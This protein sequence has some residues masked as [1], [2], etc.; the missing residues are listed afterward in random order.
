MCKIESLNNNVKNISV[1]QSVKGFSII[2][3]LIAV[4]LTGVLFI[5]Y[6]NIQ[7]AFFSGTKKTKQTS[8]ARNLSVRIDY[9]LNQPDFC[10]ILKNCDHA[11][12]GLSVCNLSKMD[13]EFKELT[14]EADKKGFEVLYNIKK[15]ITQRDEIGLISIR[16]LFK[17]KKTGKTVVATSATE[18]SVHLD[19]NQKIASCSIK[20]LENTCDGRGVKFL[21]E[22]SASSLNPTNS[23]NI[24]DLKLIHR[25]DGQSF[26]FKSGNI[27]NRP[28]LKGEYCLSQNVCNRGQWI[29]SA[30]C[31]DSCR[32]K[33]W[34]DGQ[35]QYVDAIE[36]E[37]DFVCGDL[38]NF[39]FNSLGLPACEKANLE[40]KLNFTT[41]GSGRFNAYK[42][43][44]QD[45][46]NSD[47]EI[48]A[49]FSAYFRCSYMGTWILNRVKCSNEKGVAIWDSSSSGAKDK[50]AL[51]SI[52]CETKG[53]SVLLE[54]YNYN[55]KPWETHKDERLKAENF[56]KNI[57]LGEVFSEKK[58][59]INE[60]RRL[61]AFF[62]D[63]P[64]GAT[65]LCSSNKKWSIEGAPVKNCDAHQNP[66][67]RA[68]IIFVIDNSGSMGG[69]Q[70]ALS[71]AIDNFISKFLDDSA[72]YINFSIT[73]TTTD[74]YM[75]PPFK[76][77]DIEKGTDR[78]RS[79][80]RPGTGGSGDERPLRALNAVL[81]ATGSDHR[82]SYQQKNNH[83]A[84]FIITDENNSET[85]LVQPIFDKIM[86]WKDNEESQVTVHAAVNGGYLFCD[87]SG[88]PQCL[89][90][91]FKGTL[92]DVGKSN[93]GDEMGRFAEEIIGKILVI[94]R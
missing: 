62:P 64:T 61:L 68:D 89:T 11:K 39:N 40:S 4:S 13:G 1:N 27:L 73:V 20:N 93:Y 7:T 9:L 21:T 31:Y 82:E 78:L 25:Q 74:S 28:K 58:F 87:N 94:G 49:K 42:V 80:M 70:Q 2:E 38:K 36:S 52:Q 34:R 37:V 43:H 47:K 5:G 66:R 14:D 15:A 86:R 32:N 41:G 53:H 54:S 48:T 85:Y 51:N 92:F 76:K 18:V 10:P 17:D 29:S 56:K 33:F 69:E 26:I 65:I 81:N 8:E 6:V 44:T 60:P 22:F 3:T 67:P 71:D 59:K 45:I 55:E 88:G 84:I 23:Q 83:L 72:K 75:R 46:K 35:P 16:L 57:D 79:A 24:E 90:E 77:R 91:K 63:A 12:G 19:S 50:E 30:L